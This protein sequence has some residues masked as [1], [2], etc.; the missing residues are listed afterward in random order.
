MKNFL[1][2]ITLY[3]VI[4]IIGGCKSPTDL[5]GD[6]KEIKDPLL[7]VE[8]MEES[9]KGSGL[10]DIPDFDK[11][12]RVKESKVYTSEID[13]S[14]VSNMLVSFHGTIITNSKTDVNLGVQ[15]N[16][17]YGVLKEIR[18]RLNKL[19]VTK[20]FTYTRDD[21][22]ERGA[23]IDFVFKRFRRKSGG[24]GTDTLTRI[25]ALSDVDV[26]NSTYQLKIIPNQPLPVTNEPKG[27]LLKHTFD[28]SIADG[29][30]SAEMNGTVET[31]LKRK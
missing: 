28:L 7:P 9:T 12:W 8:L 22:I 15:D 21:L 26:S 17:T 24:W 20:G 13:T 23:G 1:S 2:I 14:D 29:S 16:L 30:G 6:I 19:P 11:T 27:I 18:F 25:V 4:T 5:D 31:L 10:N 3:C